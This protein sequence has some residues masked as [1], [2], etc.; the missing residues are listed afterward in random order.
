EP[1]HH[2]T[3]GHEAGLFFAAVPAA[4]PFVG[5]GRYGR[6]GL[7]KDFQ[8]RSAPARLEPELEI[9]R[10]IDVGEF[11]AGLAGPGIAARQHQRRLPFRCQMRAFDV[12]VHFA[13]AWNSRE[14]RPVHAFADLARIAAR[15]SDPGDAPALEHDLLVLAPGP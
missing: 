13:E 7:R 4:A 12:L 3:F 9:A 10:A 6:A 2:Q 14:I 11:V 1:G 15:W 5:G 8:R